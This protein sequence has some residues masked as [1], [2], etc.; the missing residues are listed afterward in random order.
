MQSSRILQFE[1]AI[2]MKCLSTLSSKTVVEDDGTAPTRQGVMLK[3]TFTDKVFSG[4]S[5]IYWKNSA[6]FDA[7]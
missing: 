7:H 5:Y 1:Q 4:C 3:V 6:K 2:L